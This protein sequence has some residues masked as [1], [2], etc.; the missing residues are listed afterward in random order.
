[1]HDCSKALSTQKITKFFF[2]GT[3]LIADLGASATG[4]LEGDVTGPEDSCEQLENVVLLVRADTDHV[5]RIL[6]VVILYLDGILWAKF[7][8]GIPGLP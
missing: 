2:F 5:H 3:I 6:R 1:L 8:V 4:V 7:L